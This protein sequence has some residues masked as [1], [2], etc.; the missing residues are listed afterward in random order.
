[1]QRIVGRIE[2]ENDLPRGAL[3]RPWS[4]NGCS[5][6]ALGY[7]DLN[8][9]LELRHDPMMAILTCGAARGLRASFPAS[10]RWT[11]WD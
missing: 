10:R 6:F 11:G 2:V 8:D 5:E 4:V 1:V 3:M 9:H 7:E